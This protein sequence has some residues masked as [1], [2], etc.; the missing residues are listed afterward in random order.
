MSNLGRPRAGLPGCAVCGSTDRDSNGQCHCR[1]LA[2]RLTRKHRVEDGACV[3]GS[4]A[5]DHDRHV[6]AVLRKAGLA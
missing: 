4:R 1:N 6:A 3:C 5:K 2:Y